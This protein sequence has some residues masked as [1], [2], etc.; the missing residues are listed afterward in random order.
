MLRAQGRPRWMALYVGRLFRIAPMYL[1]VVM[2]MLAVVF[3][4]TGFVLNETA[5]TLTTSVL[6]WLAL[7]VI[8]AQPD[9][10]GVQATFVLAGVTWTIWYEWAFYASLL[11]TAFAARARAHLAFVIV[12]LIVCLVA[13]TWL[14]APSAGF[15]VLFLSGMATASLL[16][17]NLRLRLSDTVA[18]TLASATLV[19]VCVTAHNGY[20]STTA[21]ALSLFFYLLCSGTT[22]FGLLTTT[23]AHRLGS[24]SYSLYLMQGLVLTLVLAIEPI[25]R[26]AMASAPG[27]WAVGALCLCGLIVCASFGFALIERPAIALGKRLVLRRA[28]GR[29]AATCRDLLSKSRRPA[30]PEPDPVARR[31][32]GPADA[33]QPAARRLGLAALRGAALRAPSA[34]TRPSNHH[35]SMA[36][37]PVVL[38]SS[39]EGGVACDD[40]GGA[41]GPSSA[42]RIASSTCCAILACAAS[43]G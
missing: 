41:T 13:K 6:Q 37:P 26:T 42:E 22:L 3:S 14:H 35:T 18:S 2:V 8:D 36:P 21:I 29:L 7:G 40:D 27:A 4:R 25:R 11:L 32:G 19:A 1:F 10:N 39:C 24:I 15:A 9:V 20:A 28:A 16:H 38:A 31:V 5:F 12:A 17:E 23:P 30:P 43:V 33:A 34:A